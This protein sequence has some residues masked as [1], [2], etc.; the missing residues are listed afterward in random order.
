VYQKLREF[1]KRHELEWEE[2]HFK[3]AL[4]DRR[5]AL[6]N[7]MGNAIADL[8]AVLGGAGKGN[9]IWKEL[10]GAPVTKERSDQ[11]MERERHN[12]TVFWKSAEHPLHAKEWT[13]NVSHELAQ[14]SI[15]RFW[16]KVRDPETGKTKTRG[17]PG[18]ARPSVHLR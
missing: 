1:R 13:D 4:H 11:A 15:P 10:P 3:L 5:V 12:V 9:K 7:Q 18:D 17:A 8:A 14:L 6:K 2:D 16:T